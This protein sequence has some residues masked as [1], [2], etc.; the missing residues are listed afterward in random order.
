LY[1]NPQIG[2]DARNEIN[3]RLRTMESD[4]TKADN[5]LKSGNDFVK[6]KKYDEAI[7]E[8][9]KA[10]EINPNF[11]A[12]YFNRGLVEVVLGQKEKGCLDLSKASELGEKDADK[13]I[14]KYCK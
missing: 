3:E 7:A 5:C 10:I 4:N 6:S 2:N 14:Q 12:A 1:Y 8:F 13:M 11:K 9:S